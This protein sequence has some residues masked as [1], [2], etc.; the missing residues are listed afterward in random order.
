MNNNMNVYQTW[1]RESGMLLL[2]LAEEHARKRTAAES[3]EIISE[4]ADS[5]VSETQGT[6]KNWLQINF[7]STETVIVPMKTPGLVDFGAVQKIVDNGRCCQ[8]NESA[9]KLSTVPIQIEFS[10]RMA[11]K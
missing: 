3:T 4:T 8:C 5:A 6:S 10:A 1:I 11:Y 7:I 2:V 9:M